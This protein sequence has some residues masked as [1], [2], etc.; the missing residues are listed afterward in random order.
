[1]KHVLSVLA[2]VIASFVTQALSHFVIFAAHYREIAFSRPDP[3][4]ALGIASMLI[5]GT[6][7]S[8]IF[9]HTAWASQG[10]AKAILYALMIGAILVSYEALAEAAKYAVPHIVSWIAV[11]IASGT[12]QFALVGVGLWLAHTVWKPKA[13]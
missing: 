12:V 11:E 4:F 13:A 2:Y 8:L 9:A 7:I 1:M 10:V 5:Q 3:I 6:V